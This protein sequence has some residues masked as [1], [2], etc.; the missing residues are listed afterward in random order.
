MKI[1][2]FMEGR[3]VD[4]KALISDGDPPYG[5]YIYVNPFNYFFLRKHPE[6]LETAYYRVDGIYLISL[7]KLFLPKHLNLYRQS[8]DMTSLAPVVLS[9]CERKGLP[10]YVAGGA[11]GD[12]EK[13]CHILSS[14]FPNLHFAGV[15]SGYLSEDEIIECVVTSGAQVALLGLGNIKQESVAAKL[16]QSSKG[17]FFTCGAFISQTARSNGRHYYPPWINAWNL[18]WLFRFVNERHVIKR[19][20]KYYPLFLLVFVSDIFAASGSRSSAE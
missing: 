16:S 2:K 6:L 11:P 12:A 3:Y 5:A 4:V 10:V 17:V 15:C 18:R 19:V 9:Y 13:F 14:E 20:F 1:I 7:L 8:F